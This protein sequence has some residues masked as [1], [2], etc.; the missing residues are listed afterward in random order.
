MAPSRVDYLA[1]F[2]SATAMLRALAAFLHGRD[3]ANLGLTSALKPLVIGAN[4]LPTRLRQE[5]YK[6]G[7]YFEAVAPDRLERVRDEDIGRWVVEQYPAR[8]YPAVL[9]G[10]SN[11]A[12]VHL[13][14]AMGAPW[15]PQTFLIPVRQ[16]GIEI[17]EPKQALAFGRE[18]GRRLLEANPDLQL[19][20]MHD[21]NQDRLMTH[22]MTYFRIKRR[23]LGD[24]YARFLAGCLQPGGII[25]LVE[26]H[27][28]W[29]T[30]RVGPRHVFQM[31]GSGGASPAEYLYGGP[32]VARWFAERGLKRQRWD[33]PAPDGESPEAEWGFEETLRAEVERFADAHGYRVIRVVVD[34]P[35][36]PSPLVADLYR[37]WY[38]VRGLP[39]NR[40]LVDSFILM[41]PCWTLRLGAVPFWMKFNTEVS[42]AALERY[43]DEVEPYDEIH[44]MLFAH[45][46]DSIGLTPMERWR[47]LLTRARQR[48]CFVGVDEKAYPADFAV[49]ARYH[50]A[51]RKI[52][53]RFPLPAPLS[54]AEFE[55]FIGRTHADRR[56][57]V[58]IRGASST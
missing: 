15:L 48:G 22:Y 50:P 25:I 40:L 7:G 12:L 16:R 26:C 21:P 38:R 35:E 55:Q 47:S 17:D 6:L 8:R 44:L 52:S 10:S 56:T 42:A 30:T 49:F 13:A 37:W 28:G 11:G 2:D 31:G 20:Q 4:L 33:A 45:G 19:H 32:R 53:G 36:D 1:D 57:G 51:L 24:A 3:F 5:V 9:V 41:D 18:P 58:T 34:E 23:R 39:A 14:A 27:H 43:L 29:P 54:W 46:V